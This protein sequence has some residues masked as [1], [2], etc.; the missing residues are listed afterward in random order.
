MALHPAAGSRS[1]PRG[2]EEAIFKGLPA[3]HAASAS[4]C[5]PGSAS[6]VHLRGAEAAEAR[7]HPRLLARAEPAAGHCP[8]KKGEEDSRAPERR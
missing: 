1:S 4:K 6:F 8:F 2:G 3:A 5:R 7:P